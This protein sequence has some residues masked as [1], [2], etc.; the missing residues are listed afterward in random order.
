MRRQ[1]NKDRAWAAT[2]AGLTG[3]NA[4][5]LAAAIKG[6]SKLWTPVAAAT[7]AYSASQ[8]VQHGRKARGYNKGPMEGIR[9]KARER[10][11]AGTYGHD[12]GLDP[13][14]KAIGVPRPPAPRSV[15][16][17]MLR[18][19]TQRRAHVQRRPTGRLVS[20]RSSFG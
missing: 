9:R 12:R 19:P 14:G 3:V 15:P 11:A 17:G 4:V 7:T 10:A 16:K 18:R 6:R 2:Q 5:G 8:A 13:V 1:R 20:V